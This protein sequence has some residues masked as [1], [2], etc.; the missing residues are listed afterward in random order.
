[1]FL[2]II[3]PSYNR[4]VTLEKCYESLRRQTV[5]DFQWIIIDD[6]STDDTRKYIT[7]LREENFPIAYYY[8]QNGGKHTALN[9]SMKYITGKVVAVLDS[10]DYLIDNA[11]ELIIDKWKK[12]INNREIME[13]VFKRKLVN[14]EN[15]SFPKY[16]FIANHIDF[17]ENG[18][19]L[20]DCFE[21]VK[22]DV[23]CQFKYPEFK[24][25][26]FLGESVFR[27]RAAKKYQ[28]VYVDEDICICEYRDDGLTSHVREINI[29]SPKGAM[30]RCS[31]YFDPTYTL[32]IRFKNMLLF[33]TFAFFANEK[34]SYMYKMSGECKKIFCLSFIPAVMIWLYW[35]VKYSN[36]AK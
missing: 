21:V 11:V 33:I 14:K 9:Y 15:K 10:D 1:M 4:K 30:Y 16:E 22:K 34:V 8:K 3:T 31:L 19:Y 7:S 2:S 13:V 36:V 23:F 5:K 18:Q 24:N 12:Y 6:G 35:K 25:E 20:P 26:L 17:V 29:Q 27:C 28:S 32:K